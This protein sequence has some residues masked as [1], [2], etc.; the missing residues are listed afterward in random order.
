VVEVESIARKVDMIVREVGTIHIEVEI[1]VRTETRIWTQTGCS[2][3]LW[4]AANRSHRLIR[5][6]G[7]WSIWTRI[8]GWWRSGKKIWIG[9][10]ISHVWKRYI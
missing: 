3:D 4:I 6:K 2:M 5:S 7:W 1:S 8:R 10:K 9:L